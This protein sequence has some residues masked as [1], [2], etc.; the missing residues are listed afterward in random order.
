MCHQALD[1]P[2]MEKVGEN[3]QRDDV[4]M[5]PSWKVAILKCG[6]S[7]EFACWIGRGGVFEWSTCS[8]ELSSRPP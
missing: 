3:K 6:T 5:F 7:I 4:P 8:L 2:L 1:R